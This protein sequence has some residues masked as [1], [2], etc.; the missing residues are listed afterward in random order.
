MMYGTDYYKA[1]QD[2][3]IDGKPLVS[4]TCSMDEEV[5][6]YTWRQGPHYLEAEV[7][8]LENR[9]ELFYKNRETYEMHEWDL[10]FNHEVTLPPTLKNAMRLFVRDE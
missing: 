1:L 10:D 8:Y 4:P 2:V 6:M 9:V 3:T 5:V 7:Y